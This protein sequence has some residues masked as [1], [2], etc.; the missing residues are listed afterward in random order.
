MHKKLLLILPLG[1]MMLGCTASPSGPRTLTLMAHDSFAVSPEVLTQFESEQ[2]ATVEILLSGDAGTMVNQAILSQG[3]PLA[4]VLYGVDNSFL[5]RALDEGIFEPYESPLLGDIPDEFELDP[6][7]RALPVDYGDVCLNYEI[8][9]FEENGLP[10]PASLDDLLQP[11]YRGLLTVEN[12]ATSSPGLAFLFTTIAAYGEAGYLDYWRGLL[13]NEVEIV[14]DWETAYYS[15]FSQWGGPDPLVVSY[16]SS[17]PFEVLFSETP[18]ETPPTAAITTDGTCFRQVEFVGILAGS[19][20]RELA[21]AWVDFMLSTAFQEDIP[22]KMFVFPV[23]PNA[24]L[25]P[26]FVEFLAVPDNPA[27]LD[28]ALIAEKREAWLREWTETILR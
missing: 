9:Y 14:N 20:N 18:I 24:T 21:E 2:N 7:H 27:S 12:P 22:L 13:E 15:A 26:A 23:N 1:L 8:A 16:G 6:E 28:P 11:E 4:D 3:A 10:V 19:E 5:S 25:D 17:P